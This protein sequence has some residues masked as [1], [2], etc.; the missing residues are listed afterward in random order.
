MAVVLP[1]FTK[2]PKLTKE[3]I[4]RL[5]RYRN[6]LP[7]PTT[8]LT[9]GVPTIQGP[10]AI[11]VRK[12]YYL[13]NQLALFSLLVRCDQTSLLL[14]RKLC[15][16]MPGP[17][18]PSTLCAFLS[19]KIMKRGEFVTHHRTGTTVA[20]H[21]GIPIRAEG[22]WKCKSNLEA[23]YSAIIHIGNLYPDLL[24]DRLAYQSACPDCAAQYDSYLLQP[25]DPARTSS[26]PPGPCN[27]CFPVYGNN[28]QIIPKGCVLNDVH[29]KKHVQTMKKMM[30]GHVKA[31][32]IQLLP[33][34]MRVIREHLLY[35]CPGDR[36]TSL[37]NLQVYTMFLVGINLFLRSE[38]LLQ[39][40][41]SD[42]VPA[43]T[44]FHWPTGK[45]YCLVFKVKG[46]SDLRVHYLR[47]W[48]NNSH[49]EFCP[50][51]HLLIYIAMS[52]RTDGFVFPSLDNA[53][54]IFEYEKFLDIVKNLCVKVAG[55]KHQDRRFGTHILRKT[56]Y[57]FAI[58]GTL[59]Q[60]GD[61]H[62]Q[63]TN[64]FSTDGISLS[65]IMDS[66]RH[67][68]FTNAATYAKDGVMTY[69]A[70]KLGGAGSD[71]AIANRCLE[72][73][74]IHA[75]NLLSLERVTPHS[76]F[77][78]QPL[79]F[80]A[81]WF[82]KTKLRL[83][84]AS[85]VITA[86]TAAANSSSLNQQSPQD[87]F[88]R[89]QAMHAAKF[90]P[91][92]V[93]TANGY[94]EQIAIQRAI[95]NS[96]STPRSN[97]ESQEAPEIVPIRPDQ[98]PLGASTTTTTTSTTLRPPKKRRRGS[99]GPVNLEFRMSNTWKNMDLTIQVERL[100]E[101]VKIPYAQ[102]TNSARTFYYSTAAPIAHCVEHC[103]DSDI[104]KFISHLKHRGITKI[105][106][107]TKYACSQCIQR[108]QGNK[109]QSA[110]AHQQLNPAP[111]QQRG[112]NP[113]PAQQRLILAPAQVAVLGDHRPTT[114]G[115]GCCAIQGCVNVTLDHDH[116]CFKQGCPYFVHNFCAQ[117]HHLL[118][119][120]N[121][122]NMYCSE[123]CK[124][125]GY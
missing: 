54:K 65:D 33:R 93:A 68:S 38:E 19:Y 85:T 114:T 35:Q 17:I 16:D 107:T 5:T 109:R 25:N 121:E 108:K 56:G 21:R 44:F 45:I 80:C 79:Q 48:A 11:T 122:L 74:P 23:L 83:T 86:I 103:Y 37:N 34:D 92:E 63:A 22:G 72:W 55:Y 12:Y 125:Q 73:K 58:F 105:N 7:F 30:E 88:Q 123:S 40:Q 102:L 106:K 51:I 112:L 18:V 6:S 94:M 10:K 20:D 70:I 115:C 32:C 41:F 77:V 57:L 62:R 76:D 91:E 47:L 64:T 78:D 124:G 67:K 31:G 69:H 118:D 98:Q 104:P 14:F 3:E 13:L 113:A 59:T 89:L 66:A 15:P 120:D 101:C 49:P 24:G 100:V 75:H 84:T 116:R 61:G 28:P 95:E 8:T 2:L 71:Y 119:N 60:L 81:K 27:K 36:C 39:L 97:S 99:Y 46:K 110:P 82:Y 9:N 87:A 117:D 26:A 50:V 42:F 96:N 43:Y 111:A 52:G 53:N 29:V 4:E 1:A 90:T